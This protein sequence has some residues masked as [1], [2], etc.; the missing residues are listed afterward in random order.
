MQLVSSAI[1]ALLKPDYMPCIARN[2]QLVRVRAMFASRRGIIGAAMALDG[3]HVP[4]VPS[5]AATREDYH[6]YKGWYS[7]ILPAGADPPRKG[8]EPATLQ[9]KGKRLGDTPLGHRRRANVSNPVGCWGA[10]A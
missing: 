5:A 3:T 7:M 8:L 10:R 4:W 9:A 1:I 6:N 2:D